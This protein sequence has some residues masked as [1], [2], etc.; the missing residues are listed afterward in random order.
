MK[1]MTQAHLV[2]ALGLA[3][4]LGA[5]GCA[6]VAGEPIADRPFEIAMKSP[7]TFT[8]AGKDVDFEH[9]LKTLKRNKVSQDV[10]L[11]IDIPPGTP[12]ETIKH[13]T[14]QL[15]SAGFKPVFRNPRHARSGTRGQQLTPAP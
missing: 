2:L 10:P 1:T 14:A 3:I 11:L 8:I 15:A 12:L 5:T 4:L 6:T 7:N 9:L 13:L